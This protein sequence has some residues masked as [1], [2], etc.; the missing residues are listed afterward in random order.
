[1]VN[2]LNHNLLGFFDNNIAE[3][4][5]SDVGKAKIVTATNVFAHIQD[6]DSFMTALKK[7]LDE[8]GIFMFHVPYF[9]HLIK[10]LEYDTIYHEHV[11]YFGLKPLIT[12][13]KRYDMEIFEVIESDLDGGS[14]R[15]FVC[16]KNKKN[17]SK[18]IKQMLE[19]ENEED[20]Y[21]LDRLRD[22]SKKVLK[23]KND[24]LKLLIDL[25][26]NG[27]RIVGLSAPAKG[28][29]L[30]NYCKIDSYFLDYVTEKS[31]LKIDKYTPGMH[32]H[33]RSDEH[34]IKDMPDYALILAWNFA[35]EIMDNLREFRDAGGKFI[36]PVPSP[37]IV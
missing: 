14:I 2:K 11:C 31:P 33:I 28:I 12:F 30:L 5:L 22:F 3:K 35:N 26:N 23:Q 19:K 9:L 21:S 24:L 27:N 4:V 25:K 16:H 17:I 13:F 29:T 36:I 18:S 8:D 37:K 34:L 20:I 7:V 6:Y 15:C 1:M 32:H 10:N